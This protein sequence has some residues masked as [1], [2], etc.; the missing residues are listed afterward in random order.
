[1]WKAETKFNPVVTEKNRTISKSLR[2]YLSNIPGKHEIQELQTNSHTG[3]CTHTA[4]SD[5]VKVQ[6]IFYRQNNITCST[7]FKYRTET[8]PY[9][10]ET[11]FVSGIHL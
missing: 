6:N 7:Y 4:E 8:T 9:T 3:H 1:M 5:N 11:W 10:L 2:R